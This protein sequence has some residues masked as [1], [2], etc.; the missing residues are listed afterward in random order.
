MNYAPEI[1]FEME[2]GFVLRS[3]QLLQS[4]ARCDKGANLPLSGLRGAGPGDMVRAG[5]ASCDA[6]LVMAAPPARACSDWQ[7]TRTFNLAGSQPHIQ[8]RW[9]PTK[10]PGGVTQAAVT[11]AGPARGGGRSEHRDRR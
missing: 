8:S 7:S 9:L 5:P 10:H 2:V 11:V 4:E 6:D 1:Y 3:N